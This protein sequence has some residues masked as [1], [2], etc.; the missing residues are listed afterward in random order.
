MNEKVLERMMLENSLRQALSNN[1]L[2][3]YYQPLIDGF[4]GRTTGFEALVRWQH[5]ERGLVP[6][7]D[8][9]PLA[10]ETGLI[11]PIG[12]WVLRTAC[13]QNKAWQDKGYPPVVVSVNLSGRQFRQPNFTGRV[14]HVL[15]ATGLAPE[16]LELEITESI[17]L[18]D[19]DYTIAILSELGAM[20]IKIAIDDFGTGYSSLSY[21]KRFPITTLKIDRIFIQDATQ[22][23]QDAAIISAI[24]VLAHNLRLKVVAEGVET[25]EQRLFLREMNCNTMQGYLFSRPLPAAQVENMLDRQW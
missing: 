13:A 7:L 1:E 2:V 17:A 20:G 5:P 19:V 23:A 21:L 14:S 16:Y 25:G 11:V 12:E 6:P 10:E 22:D 9:I 15:A 18:H 8:F 24:I 4:T 3:V